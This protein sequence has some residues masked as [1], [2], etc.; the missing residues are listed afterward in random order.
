MRNGGLIW[1]EG[2]C[3]AF[4]IFWL[5]VDT[6]LDMLW[7]FVPFLIMGALRFMIVI[8][9]FG[10]YL[11]SLINKIYEAKYKKVEEDNWHLH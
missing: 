3:T 4:F 2:I 6:G 1:M 8:I 10:L 9:I 11:I 7:G 5:V